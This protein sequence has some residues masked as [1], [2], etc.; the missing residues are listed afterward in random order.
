M[1]AVNGNVECIQILLDAGADV[2]ACSPTCPTPLHYA[3]SNNHTEC[4]RLLLER[5]A[6]PDAEPSPG[7]TPLHEAATASPECLNLI[8]GYGVRVNVREEESGM[9]PLMKCARYGLPACAEILL[10]H[11]ADPDIRNNEGQTALDI[12]SKRGAFGIVRILK[13]AKEA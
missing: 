5:G 11:G 1:A 10:R 12:A 8:L 6:S 7:Y 9:T 2:N 13:K 4:A 3:L